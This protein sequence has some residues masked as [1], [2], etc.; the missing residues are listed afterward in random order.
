MGFLKAS[1]RLI[2]SYL[3]NKAMK[4]QKKQLFIEQYG[5]GTLDEGKKKH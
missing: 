4:N 2:R 5:S 3:C 1:K